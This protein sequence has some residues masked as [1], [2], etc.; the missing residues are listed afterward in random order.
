MVATTRRLT[1]L[2][3]AM[4]AHGIVF[5]SWLALRPFGETGVEAMSDPG[6]ALPAA[7]GA[8]LAFLAAASSTG[9][10]RAAWFFIAAALAS[11]SFAEMTWST[12]ELL[13]GQETP[14]P[15]IADVWYLGAVPLMCAGVVLLS[16]PDRSLARARTALHAVAI[17][18]TASAIV[19]HAVLLPTYSDS[20]ATALEKVIGGSYP[21]ATCF[22]SLDW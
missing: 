1:L 16:S 3:V 19:W 18:F 11:W 14:F 8:G 22:S 13:L 4:A 20:Q 10:V 15:S 12:Y 6:M 17:V 21:W 7:A 9:Q 5:A 2:A